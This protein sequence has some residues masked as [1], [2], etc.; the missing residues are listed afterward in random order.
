M[1]NYCFQVGE[2]SS[3]VQR[4]S[5]VIYF[6]WDVHIH[7]PL[8]F[9]QLMIKCLGLITLVLVLTNIEMQLTK[10][11]GAFL[12][13]TT[14]F[15]MVLEVNISIVRFIKFSSINR[16]CHK[17]ASLISSRYFWYRPLAILFLHFF[18]SPLMLMATQLSLKLNYS[19]SPLSDE[20]FFPA[21]FFSARF[22]LNGFFLRGL[23]WVGKKSVKF[24]E[25]F[26]ILAAL[27]FIDQK[28]RGFSAREIP[29]RVKAA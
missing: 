19:L 1:I 17:L 4:I 8:F 11:T 28:P 26:H 23:S 3:C 27:L 14:F 15:Y 2:S 21:R 22:F 25:T 16:K 5:D 6:F 18:S 9:L 29:A 24:S 13:F 10:S 7:S 20:H 12:F